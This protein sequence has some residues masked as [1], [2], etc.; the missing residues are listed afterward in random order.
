MQPILLTH[1]GAGS[2]RSVQDAADRAGR[3]GLEILRRGGRALDAVVQAVVVLEDDP[4]LNAGTGSRMRT[5]GRI[6][7]DAAVMDGNLDAGAVAAIERVKNPVRVAKDVLASPHILFVGPDAVAFARARG[8]AEYDPA[9]PESRRKLEESLRQIREGRV[10]RYYRKFNHLE[11]HDTVGAVARDR[12]G[13]CAAA[14]STGGTSFML[15][16]RVGDSPILGSGLYAGPHGAVCATGVGEEIMRRVASKFVYD[17]MASGHS[18]QR[19]AAR[20]LALFPRDVSFG[21]IAVGKRGAG[22]ACDRDMAYFTS[23]RGRTL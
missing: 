5:D 2:D 3:A 22:E 14:V 21:V 18:P 15:P 7:M 11:I 1:C 20:A 17:Q 10:P 19:A 4:R 9:T 6:Q 13:R 8:H 23:A 16:G 12:R